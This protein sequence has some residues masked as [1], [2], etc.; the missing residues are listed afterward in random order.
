MGY[1]NY[2]VKTK[3]KL[4]TPKCFY[5]TAVASLLCTKVCAAGGI[6]NIVLKLLLYKKTLQFYSLNYSLNRKNYNKVAPEAQA[7]TKV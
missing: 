5:L 4:S 7:S 3:N 2:K 6:I 1:F